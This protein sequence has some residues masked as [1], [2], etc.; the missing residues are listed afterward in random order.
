MVGYDMVSKM[1]SAIFRICLSVLSCHSGQWGYVHADNP[2]ETSSFS[3]TRESY[4]HQFYLS[5]YIKSNKQELEIRKFGY[6]SGARI[7]EVV[8]MMK[9]HVTLKVAT[10]SGCWSSSYRDDPREVFRR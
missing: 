1:S 3:L 6:K 10:L 2:N 9:G 5:L 7:A 8:A 4:E